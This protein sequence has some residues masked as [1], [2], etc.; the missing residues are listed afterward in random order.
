MMFPHANSFQVGANAQAA[1]ISSRSGRTRRS[2]FLIDPKIANLDSAALGESAICRRLGAPRGAPRGCSARCW[3]RLAGDQHFPFGDFSR[4][5]SRL[6][7]K[8]VPLP[9]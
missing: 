8:A 2:S 1:H 9:G 7:D 3:A 6:V 4:H 5:A